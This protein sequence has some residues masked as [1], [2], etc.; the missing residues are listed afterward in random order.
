MCKPDSPLNKVFFTNAGAKGAKLLTEVNMVI[1]NKIN[2]T[3][4]KT[5]L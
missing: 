4:V 3:D 2:N 5:W 1:E